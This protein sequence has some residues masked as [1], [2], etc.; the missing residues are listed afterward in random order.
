MVTEELAAYSAV[1]LAGLDDLPETL[2]S[3]SVIVQDAA[4]VPQ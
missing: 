2:M 3:R 4:S 1:A